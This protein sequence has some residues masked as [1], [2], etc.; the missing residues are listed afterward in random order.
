MKIKTNEMEIST[1]SRTEWDKLAKI[2]SQTF[3]K[4]AAT[5]EAKGEFVYENYDLLKYHEFFALLVPKEL[6]GAGLN[7]S[8]VCKIIRTIG[9]SCGSTAL[10]FSMHQH[11]VAATTWKYKNKGVGAPLL[12][13]VAENQLVLVSTGARDW[14]GSNGNMK[15]VEGG[16]LVNAKKGFA[17]QSAVGDLLVTS[18]PYQNERN[19]WKVLHFGVPFSDKGVSLLDDWKVMGMRATGSQ[20]VV[21]ENVFVPDS[22]I[23]LERE[24]NEFHPVWNVVLTV[25]MPLIMSAYVGIAER[26][27]SLAIVRT[28]M[29]NSNNHVPYLLGQLNNSWMAALVQWQAMYERT[30]ELNFT[31]NKR[32]AAEILA[33]K[34]NVAE[35]CIE[36]VK[37]AIELVGGSSFYE[38]SELERLFRDVQASQF[39]PLPK[40]DQYA[41]TSSVLL[42]N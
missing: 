2:L 24:Q 25:A 11:L 26:A 28:N 13:K 12:N 10:A 42:N 29:K 23:A 31:A 4:N 38:Q 20:T 40:W 15:K 22:A 3:S 30:D 35:A 16:Y 21:L 39:H 36:P 41:F 7:Y 9:N 6:G 14:L 17:S 33:L 37:L 5:Q 18:A 34:T 8:E 27:R 1:A 32:I 19:Q